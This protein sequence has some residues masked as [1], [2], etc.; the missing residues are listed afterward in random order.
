[1]ADHTAW[2]TCTGLRNYCSFILE[3]ELPSFLVKS[4]GPLAIPG[5]DLL[6]EGMPLSI[7]Q[8]SLAS[9]NYSTN[10]TIYLK[11]YFLCSR[12]YLENIICSREHLKW[13]FNTS[14]VE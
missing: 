11:I 3:T 12:E 2:P 7:P 5:Y 10:V 14:L 6:W 4:P 8:K 9:G 13:L 1:M